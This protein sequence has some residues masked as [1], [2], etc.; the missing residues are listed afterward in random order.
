MTNDVIV[1]QMQGCLNFDSRRAAGD[2]VIMFSCGG[3]ADGG[4]SSLDESRSPLFQLS[5]ILFRWRNH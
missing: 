1:I 3:R 2:T 4:M 5:N